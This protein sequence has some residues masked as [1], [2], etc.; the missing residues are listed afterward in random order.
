MAD[1]AG[2]RGMK[3]SVVIP[4]FQSQ[5]T[6]AS[7]VGQVI[8]VL[9]QRSNVDFELVLVNDGSTDQTFAVIQDLAKD[10]RVKGLDLSKNFGQPN[11][12]L[13]G[14]AVATGEVIVYCDDDGQTPID[15]VWALIDKLQEGHDVV[16]AKFAVKETS[17]IAKLGSLLN[18]ATTSYLTGKPK[19]LHMGNFWVAR[20]FV[21]EEIVR[22]RNPFPHVGGLLATSAGRFAQ[23]P[24][25]HRP[26]EHGKSNYTFKK[27]VSL[28]WNG[29]TG[30]SALPLRL[31]TAVGAATGGMGFILL[32]IV[33]IRWAF[34]PETPPGYTSTVSLILCL[35]GINLFV[36]GLVGDYVG[37]SFLALTG[38]PQYVRR[39]TINLDEEADYGDSVV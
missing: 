25:Q 11:A 29:V 33:V 10:K 7:V 22:S 1:E 2:G 37:R 32:A 23:V 13:A 4:C 8:Q 30:F 16:F 12:S 36:V 26:R 5:Q 31:I 38:L 17:R 20:R 21:V 9:E 27:L 15:E 14:F 6:L 35:G 19:G 39:Q 34:E 3:V 24:T 28:W 18:S